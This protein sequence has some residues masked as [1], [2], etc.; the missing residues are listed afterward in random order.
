MHDQDKDFCAICEV[1]LF[2]YPHDVI[3]LCNAC[4]LKVRHLKMLLNYL[5]IRK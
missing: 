5:G 4:A 3:D 1:A 2:G